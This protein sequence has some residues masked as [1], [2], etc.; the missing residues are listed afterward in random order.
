[1]NFRGKVKGILEGSKKKGKKVTV[2]QA[3]KTARKR[4]EAD[5]DPK[6]LASRHPDYVPTEEEKS[7]WAETVAQS[8]ARI[9][10]HVP[11]KVKESTTTNEDSNHPFYQ[12]V[13]ALSRNKKNNS[14][15]ER[16]SKT[17]KLLI[18]RINPEEKSK[19]MDEGPDS[20]EFKKLYRRHVQKKKS[21]ETEERSPKTK[22]GHEVQGDI[23]PDPSEWGGDSTDPEV[24]KKQVKRE[25]DA[26][27]KPQKKK[28]R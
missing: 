7:K 13:K 17:I 12:K 28:K 4:A 5:V 2:A 25:M 10:K 23:D 11:K 18:G 24:V 9:K 3:H 14:L 6:V 26:W 19:K 20:E 1:M 27:R 8:T 15:L 16:K 22:P 21:K